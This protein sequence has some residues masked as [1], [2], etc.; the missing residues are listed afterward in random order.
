[1]GTG[2]RPVPTFIVT[3][4]LEAMDFSRAWVLIPAYLVAAVS[5]A[6][7]YSRSRGF[8]V[9]QRDF[10]GA[11]GMGRQFGWRVGVAI[12]VVDVLKGALAAGVV[13]VFAPELIWFAPAVVAL[14]HCYPV[15]H[16][17]NGGQGLAPATG[18][19]WVVDVVVGAVAMLG[20]LLVMGVHRTF[21]LERFV[22]LGAQPL[23]GIVTPLALVIVA[24]TRAGSDGV[25]GV[26]LMTAVLLARGVHVLLS[27]KPGSA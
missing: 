14:G 26:L 15:W 17:F 6:V 18:A 25:I 7:L 3:G 27:P 20:G 13:R 2:F 19:L 22:K 9:R 12:A 4:T 16:G 23:S 8:D 11:S 1:V 24:Q 21:K 5:V 10:A